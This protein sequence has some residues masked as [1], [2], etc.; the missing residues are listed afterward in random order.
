MNFWL[1]GESFSNKRIRNDFSSNQTTEPSDL[2][3]I[4]QF[5]N[6]Y[7]GTAINVVVDDNIAYLADDEEGLLILDVTDPTN[8]VFLS[9][10]SD[11]SG[12]AWDLWIENDLL[13]LADHL[14]GLEIID[15]SN[16]TNPIK[17]GEFHD[18]SAA[19]CVE[20]RDDL[21]F[22]ADF[23]DGLEILDISDPSNPI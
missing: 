19:L 6:N 7:G 1:N 4:G 22:V 23:T 13:Y 12:F 21:A 15:V 8:P 18:G 10:Y 3:E 11:G 14:D 16:P 5:D 17:I 20:V 9:Q 2:V